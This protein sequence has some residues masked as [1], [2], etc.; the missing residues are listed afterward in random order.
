M[1]D[2]IGNRKKIITALI[3]ELFGP[4]PVGEELDFSKPVEFK[5]AE[6]A[7]G[8]WRQK[9]SGDEVLHSDGPSRRYG[10]GVLY[11]IGSIA[12]EEQVDQTGADV[13]ELLLSEDGIEMETGS[14]AE[15]PSKESDENLASDNKGLDGSSVD[16][17]TGDFDLSSANAYKPSSIGVSFL[18]EF[19]PNTRLV[20]E[21]SGGRYNPFKVKIEDVTRT[22]WLRSQVTLR[23]EFSADILCSGQ[24]IIATPTKCESENVEGL[25]IRVEVFSRQFKNRSDLR[26]VTVCLVNR[27]QASSSSDEAALFQSKF[28]ATVIS[29]KPGPIL[30]YPST[31]GEKQDD[32]EQS[33]AL[34]YRNAAT[35]AVG[36]GCAA[37]WSESKRLG[38][39]DW[40][41]AECLPLFET[42]STTP[43]ITDPDGN[44][45]L[46]PMAPLAGLIPGDDG[47]D[48]LEKIVGYY[49]QWIA[50]QNEEISLLENRYQ[51]AAKR[52]LSDCERCARRMRRGIQYLLSNSHAFRAFQ[53]A[54]RAILLQQIQSRKGLRTAKYDTQTGR[55]QFSEAYSE[56]DP[57]N[58]ENGPCNWRAFQI[59][60]LL[61]SIE[62]A[63]EEDAPDR[64]SIELIWFPTGGGKTEAYL[65]L[66]A[67][68]LFMRRLKNSG[69]AGVHVL[70]RYTLRLLTA[71]QFQRASRL[72]CAMELLRQEF[73]SELGSKPFNIGLWVG[74]S[75]TPNSRESA[76]S[77]LRGL[78]RGGKNMFLLDRCPWCGVQIGPLEYSKE[79]PP[80]APGV[81]GY[82]QKGRTVVFE[83]PDSKCPFTKSLPVSVIDEDIYE[84]PP[85][86][87][88]GTV[89]KFAML[90]W[91]PEARAL[92]GIGSNG[93]RVCSPPGL[94][95]QDELHM[96]SGP[97]GSIVGL[98][99]ALIEEL[100]TDRRGA[101]P[102]KP[103][104]ITSTATIRRYADQIRAIYARNDAVL[105]PP[106]GLDEGDSFFGR[107]ARKENGDLAPGRIYIGVHAPGLGSM[108]TAQVRTF[109]ALLQA[110]MILPGEDRDPWWTLVLFFNSLRELG[111]TLSLLQADI[112]QHYQRVLLN[113]LARS[114]RMRRTISDPLELTSRAS[115]E[116]VPKAISALEVCYS[117]GTTKAIDVC[118]ASSILEVGIDIDRLSLM[119]VV[120]QPKMT[121][122]YIQVTGRV[123]RSWWERPGLVVTIYSASKPRDRSHF[124]KFRSYHERLYAQVEPTSV[125]P[126]SPPAL[127]RALHAVMVAYVRQIGKRD[128][129]NNPFPFPEE[130]IDT[131]KQILLPR[132][133]AVDPQEAGS[134]EKVFERRAREWRS[135]Q[136]TKWKATNWD[137][138]DIPLLREAGEYCTG[139]KAL[140][141]WATPTSMRS[142][143]AEAITEIMLPVLPD[144]ETGYG[145]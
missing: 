82:A 112:P 53:L 143:D 47:F 130:L 63:A 115:S 46:V 32:E 23:V 38:K 22:W 140:M 50:K 81:L 64:E 21:A 66:A 84:N 92:F 16:T 2:H 7:Y 138:E 3:E 80:N 29:H 128:L 83:C 139:A 95:I 26:L 133:L 135:W 41:S 68:A 116:D 55:I 45:I 72:I 24:Q 102:I 11:P 25:D 12:D 49:E 123:G 34:L 40:V 89:D 5:T 70:M 77:V 67:F 14:P 36:H 113:R 4:A 28:K 119:A 91:R 57:L 33:L 56:P 96:I 43:D 137:D 99:E 142:V 71:Q 122:Q 114:N 59:A 101:R 141:S 88:I 134:F 107:Y 61:M 39:V 10:I 94:I 52:H 69:D 35:Y 121:S 58:Q 37:D 98:Y 120:G 117:S 126:F 73:P 18:A 30:A 6:E 103:K 111:T 125:T 13:S 110:P 62:S 104:I 8:P 27:T 19:S 145:Q 124:E 75:N 44:Q 109:T 31:P 144:E 129:V 90:A 15:N 42:P 79:P 54:N 17:D 1:P 118:M 106:P 60:F 108:Q 20:V 85:S 97:L 93:E 51:N 132:V 100:C 78:K 127:D 9:G 86:I 76:L 74:G 87:V 105:F 131:L 136:S 65:G 48:L